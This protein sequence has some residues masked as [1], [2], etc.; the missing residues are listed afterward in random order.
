[1]TGTSLAAILDSAGN[2]TVSRFPVVRGDSPVRQRVALAGAAS[3]LSPVD[4]PAS[5]ADVSI[6]A[7][8]LARHV[9]VPEALAARCRHRMEANFTSRPEQSPNE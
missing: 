8:E 7:T 3:E 6:L 4:T 2:C 1:V 5:L 9:S